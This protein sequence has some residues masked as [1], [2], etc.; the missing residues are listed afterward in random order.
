MTDKA[1]PALRGR[2][3]TDSKTVSLVCLVCLVHLVK[4]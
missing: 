2:K 3:A 4:G 1:N